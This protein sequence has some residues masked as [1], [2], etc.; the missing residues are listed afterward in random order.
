VLELAI[1]RLHT[2]W[3][4]TKVELMSVKDE[5]FVTSSKGKK[6]TAKE[7]YET[8]QASLKDWGKYA[9]RNIWLT[10]L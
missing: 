7:L 3:T 8:I 6:V 2:T 4:A 5:D 10:S 1:P 9:T